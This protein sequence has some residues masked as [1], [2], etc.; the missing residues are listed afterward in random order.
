MFFQTFFSGY[1]VDHDGP[2]PLDVDDHEVVVPETTCPIS[3][4]TLAELQSLYDPLGLCDDFVI[5][6][7]HD[8]LQF[9]QNQIQV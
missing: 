1:G 9:V 7:Y 5:S 6:L 3:A 2:P 4:S 8:V